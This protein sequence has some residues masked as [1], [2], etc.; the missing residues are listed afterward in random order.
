MGRLDFLLKTSYLSKSGPLCLPW[1]RGN[2]LDRPRDPTVALG[3]FL[4][5]FPSSQ[6]ILSP[7]G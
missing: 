3:Q 7:V 4:E 2:R 5:E 1:T 6:E